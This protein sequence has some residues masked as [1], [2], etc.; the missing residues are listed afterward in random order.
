VLD[1]E[2]VSWKERPAMFTSTHF[3]GGKPERDALVGFRVESVGGTTGT[4]DS[5]T[6]SAAAA[7]LV[8]NTAR[9]PRSHRVVVPFG[10]INCVDPQRRRLWVERD[11][12]SVRTAPIFEPD[13]HGRE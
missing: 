2:S 10:A 8:V 6:R 11:R 4:I 12:D 3:A 13:R 5:A 9:W 1:L 7:Y